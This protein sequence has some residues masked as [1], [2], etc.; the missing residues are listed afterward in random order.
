MPNLEQTLR[1]FVTT[2]RAGTGSRNQLRIELKS[3]QKESRRVLTICGAV[4]VIVLLASLYF[5]L[6]SSNPSTMTAVIGADGVIVAGL[7]YLMQRSYHDMV[8]A[9]YL[10]SME[11]VSSDAKIGEIITSVIKTHYDQNPNPK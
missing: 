9:S 4:L 5:S 1:G 2:E 8:G 3:V 7:I 6:S 11:A 10:L